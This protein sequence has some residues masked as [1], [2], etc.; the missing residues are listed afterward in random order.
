MKHLA[1]LL[2]AACALA[3]PA[4]AGVATPHVTFIGDSV[5]AAIAQ[6]SDARRELERGLDVTLE[7]RICRKLAQRSCTYEGETPPSAL[8]V[9]K[10]TGSGLG[11]TVVI[12]VGYNQQA[13]GYRAQLAKVMR[14]LEHAQV[15]HVV[16]LTLLEKNRDYKA[17]NREIRR[18]RSQWQE[19]TVLDWAHLSRDKPWFWNDGLHLNYGGAIALARLVRATVLSIDR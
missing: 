9:I 3:G 13:A 16:W 15:K 14:A 5:P 4:A 19:L 18:A 11:D 8:E 10:T 12:N 17:I 1:A 2:L 6:I 7:L